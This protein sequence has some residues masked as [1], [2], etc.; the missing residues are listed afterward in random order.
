[1][2]RITNPFLNLAM[3]DGLYSPLYWAL[4]VDRVRMV[5][6]PIAI[7]VAES[8]DVAEDALELIDVT[9]EPLEAIATIDAA[10]DATKPKLWDRADG[11]V[12]MNTTK[13]YGDVAAAF[14]AADRVI[15]ARSTAIATPTSQWRRGAASPRS[16]PPR[17]R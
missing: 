8:R 6:D 9:Y 14:A 2:K 15:T 13:Q 17:T 1:M 10:L 5:G 7:V 3:I 4:A 12:L 16:T 11:N